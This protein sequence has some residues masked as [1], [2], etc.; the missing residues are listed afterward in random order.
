VSVIGVDCPLCGRRDCY[1]PTAPYERYAIELNPYRKARI[2]I[3][4]FQCRRSRRTFSLLPHQLIP[5]CQYTVSAVTQTI[6]AVLKARQRGQSG[7]Y[8]AWKQVDPDSNVTPWLIACWLAMVL[9]DLRR[10]HPVL[11]RRYDLTG[12][13]SGASDDSCGLELKGYLIALGVW[14]LSGQTAL[15]LAV[16]RDY[17]RGTGHFLFGIPSQ[18]R[19]PRTV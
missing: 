13:R 19:G 8:G 12:V 4:R 6:L 15:F 2:P 16:A 9:K 7:F 11:G 18:Q 17:S 3:A 5:Y 14:P 10:A 1:R